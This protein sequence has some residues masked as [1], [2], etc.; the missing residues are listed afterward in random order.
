MLFEYYCRRIEGFLIE[1]FV[2]CYIIVSQMYH[3]ALKKGGFYLVFIISEKR[4]YRF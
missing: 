4:R 1:R 2:K 3:R